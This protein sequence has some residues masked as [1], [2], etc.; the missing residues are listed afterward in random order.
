MFISLLGGRED[1]R[2]LS[3]Q[4]AFLSLNPKE[5]AKRWVILLASAFISRGDIGGE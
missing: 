5:Y 1:V 4:K 3:L 2:G